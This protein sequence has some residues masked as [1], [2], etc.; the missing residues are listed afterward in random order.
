MMGVTFFCQC[1]I[2]VKRN[3]ICIIYKKRVLLYLKLI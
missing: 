1:K 3:F 2:I